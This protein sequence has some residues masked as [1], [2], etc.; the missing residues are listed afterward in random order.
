[1]AKWLLTHLQCKFILI[2]IDYISTF[3]FKT[4]NSLK[5]NLVLLFFT[6]GRK[7]FYYVGMF[8]AIVFINVYHLWNRCWCDLSCFLYTCRENCLGRIVRLQAGFVLVISGFKRYTS[9]AYVFFIYIWC[10]VMALYIPFCRHW[11]LNGHWVALVQLQSLSVELGSE[12]TFLLC[13]W[14][15]NLRF[16]E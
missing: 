1:M 2:L 6:R 3:T 4:F 12:S 11:L 10:E 16:V 14:I 15:I 7:L 13:S 8:L 9:G 5:S